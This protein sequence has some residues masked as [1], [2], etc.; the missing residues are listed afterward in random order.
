MT[1]RGHHLQV[2]PT[3]A[4]I[5]YIP[6]PAYQSKSHAPRFA[7]RTVVFGEL[8]N[9]SAANTSYFHPNQSSAYPVSSIK[10]EIDRTPAISVNSDFTD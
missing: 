2:P 5:E 9:N 3:A 8:R 10:R 1:R 7:P 4:R 6:R